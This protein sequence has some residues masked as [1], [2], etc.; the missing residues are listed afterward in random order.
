MMMMSECRNAAS[1]CGWAVSQ[2]DIN[3]S[4]AVIAGL[5]IYMLHSNCDTACGCNVMEM[6]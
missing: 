6:S 1:S 2:F 4:T 3:A 5:E